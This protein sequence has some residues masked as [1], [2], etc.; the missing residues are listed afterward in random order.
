MCISVL[1]NGTLGFAML[2]ALLFCLGDLTD[3][4][5][6]L[7]GY[8]FIE[9]F[10]Q[11]TGSNAGASAMVWMRTVARSGN[12]DYVI[13]FCHYCDL[14]LRGIRIARNCFADDVGICS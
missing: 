11:A 10:Y 4:L 3:A 2:L 7:T 6:T 5:D 13:D 12:T 14:Y 1:L 8:P 9:I